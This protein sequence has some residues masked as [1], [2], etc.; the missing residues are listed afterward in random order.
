M[1]RGELGGVLALEAVGQVQAL[2]LFLRVEQQQA[3][4]GAAFDIGDAQLLAALEHEGGVAA[5][6]D[7]F[8]IEGRAQG[9]GGSHWRSPFNRP[10]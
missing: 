4:V 10:A 5:A 6:G 9:Q 8:F 7:G 1:T 3:D 2:A